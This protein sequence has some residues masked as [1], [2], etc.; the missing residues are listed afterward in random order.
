[1]CVNLNHT[2]EEEVMIECPECHVLTSDHEMK[3]GICVYCR[4]E[5]EAAAKEDVCEVCGGTGELSRWTFGYNGG[6]EV[7]RPCPE[8][9]AHHED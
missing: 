5:M 8:C 9:L 2:T 3:D 4:E 7:F 6:Y 1:M